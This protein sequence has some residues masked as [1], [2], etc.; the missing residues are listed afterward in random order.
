MIEESSIIQQHQK[1]E[2]TKR[3]EPPHTKQDK[4]MN[5]ATTEEQQG[6]IDNR[7]VE[8]LRESKRSRDENYEKLG[9][10]LGTRFVREEAKFG[11][12]QALQV[13]A[14]GSN[15]LKHLARGHVG[16]AGL[17]SI[18]SED[19]NDDDIKDL[20]VH[21]SDDDAYRSA[22]QVGFVNA[23]LKQFAKIEQRL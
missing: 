6:N 12:L 21:W 22:W 14:Q 18:L 2:E 23:A 15:S 17:A 4:S 10:D 16:L 1:P 11:Q 19:G 13:W 7:V 3:G 9:A 5:E 8:R 20:L